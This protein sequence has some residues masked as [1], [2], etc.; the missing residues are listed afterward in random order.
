MKSEE[1]TKYVFAQLRGVSAKAEIGRIGAIGV[2]RTGDK[3]R[4][5]YDYEALHGHEF[6]SVGNLMKKERIIDRGNDRYKEL[7]INTDTGEIVQNVEHP[8]SDHSGHGSAKYNK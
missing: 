6:N 4:G 3:T 1:L 7:V 5:K 2:S 8:L